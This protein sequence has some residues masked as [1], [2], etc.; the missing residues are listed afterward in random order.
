MVEAASHLPVPVGVWVCAALLLRRLDWGPWPRLGPLACLPPAQLARSSPAGPS[1]TSQLA[2]LAIHACCS[3]LPCTPAHLPSPR[4]QLERDPSSLAEL[5]GDDALQAALRAPEPL[6]KRFLEVAAFQLVRLSSQQLSFSCTLPGAAAPADGSSGGGGDFEF[7]GSAE[8]L[9]MLVSNLVYLEGSVAGRQMFAWSP[10]DGRIRLRRLPPARSSGRGRRQ[11]QAADVARFELA[12][13]PTDAADSAAAGAAGAQ[14]G[15]PALARLSQGQ[16]NALLD[17]M[18]AF[19]KQHPAFMHLRDFDGPLQAPEPGL[20]QRLAARLQG[21]G[22]GGAAD[23][24][25]GGQ[26]SGGEQARV[27]EAG[28]GAGGGGVADGIANAGRTAGSAVGGTFV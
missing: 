7:S 26:S 22:G 3:D 14:Q 15:Q 4:L 13:W 27:G 20:L 2:C 6:Q 8:E 18:D 21:P 19:C 9:A 25:A 11:Q 17:C 12:V 5:L 28:G 1:R 23:G 16:L 24:T 10:R